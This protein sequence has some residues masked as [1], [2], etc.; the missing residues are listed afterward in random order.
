ML[1]AYLDRWGWEVGQ[2]FEGIG[3][4]STDDDLARIAPGFP[5]VRLG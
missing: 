3:K 5:V 1:R 2:F 4:A